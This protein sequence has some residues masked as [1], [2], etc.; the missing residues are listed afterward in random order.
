MNYEQAQKLQLLMPYKQIFY[1]T[2]YLCYRLIDPSLLYS[3]QDEEGRWH[4]RKD[5]QTLLLCG[6]TE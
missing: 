6:W 5:A 3:Y 2:V 4:E 1:D